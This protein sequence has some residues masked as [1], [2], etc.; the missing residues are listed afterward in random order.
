MQQQAGRQAA[1]SPKGEPFAERQHVG[2]QRRRQLHQ[3]PF[4]GAD[5]KPHFSRRKGIER[6]FRRD[7]NEL[8]WI[9]P[10]RGKAQAIG[11]ATFST[12]SAIL[13]PQDG[14][15]GRALLLPPLGCPLSC[16]LG[17]REALAACARPSAQQA[18]GKPRGRTFIARARWMQG[19][20]ALAR[21]IATKRRKRARPIRIQ[22]QTCS[23]TLRRGKRT[24]SAMFTALV[25]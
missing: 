2:R 3:N 19:M 6:A 20:H 25:T 21:G 18:E 22:G 4:Q 24:I 9:N 1:S 15:Q 10:E 12:R 14:P 7:Q 11:P 13:H 8:R 23:R 16:P 5:F 17:C